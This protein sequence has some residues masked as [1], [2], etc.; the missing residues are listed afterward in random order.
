[1]TNPP[2]Q[3]GIGF[4]PGAVGPTPAPIHD[5][6]GPLPFGTLSPLLLAGILLLL[7]ALAVGCTFL[8]RRRVRVQTPQER[9]MEA[10]GRLRAEVAKGDDHEF[11]V[12]VSDVL[13][14][15]LGEALGLAAPRQTTE[16]F[17]QSLTGS[18][19]FLPA[20]QEALAGFLGHADRLKYAQGEATPEQRLSLI[21]A[22]ESFVRG[23]ARPEDPESPSNVPKE[24]P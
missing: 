2:A 20:E 10:L 1:M 19:R 13:R 23:G 16:E 8:L 3:P 4:A 14:R 24:A 17:L 6:V 12:M 18:L 21:G 11:G 9:A 15:F 7:V 5:I 22:A